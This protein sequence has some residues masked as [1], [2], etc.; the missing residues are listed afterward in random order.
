MRL[1]TPANRL[2]LN[3]KNRAAKSRHKKYFV[4]LSRHCGCH[5][6]AKAKDLHERSLYSM[7]FFG[8]R[9]L[10]P[11]ND[12][13]VEKRRCCR[14]PEAKPKDLPER[15]L[16]SMRFFANAQND[17]EVEKRRCR[18]HPEPK[19]KDLMGQRLSSWRFFTPQ[20]GSE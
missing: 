5:P 1:K 10:T 4:I 12:D 6:E 11:Q 15:S 20:G 2:I 14:H 19:A 18:R 8:V 9:F 7:R 13:E 3:P 16:H 17:D